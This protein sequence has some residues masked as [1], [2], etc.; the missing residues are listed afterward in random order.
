M[1]PNAPTVQ[2]LLCPTIR[3]VLHSI[4]TCRLECLQR[5]RLLAECPVRTLAT[6]SMLAGPQSLL[7]PQ[8]SLASIPLLLMMPIL[9]CHFA[10]HSP[11]AD[12][13]KTVTELLSDS[14]LPSLQ[15]FPFP[16]LV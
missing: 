1:L 8:D 6:F 12:A 7:I 9:V 15:T 11:A 14:S 13:K 2:Q 4:C 5:L 16:A 10:P 3:C